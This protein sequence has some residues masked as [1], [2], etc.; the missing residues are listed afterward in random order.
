MR[1]GN[2]SVDLNLIR[3]LCALLEE[4]HVSHAADRC[5]V[6]QP[7]MSRMLDRLRETFQ[8]ELLVRSG[9]RYERT[10]RAEQLLAEMRDVLDRVDAAISGDRFEPKR[11]DATFRVATT[12]YFSAV[13]IPQLLAELEARAPLATLELHMSDDRT[14]EHVIAG[15]IDV[16][17]VSV[18]VPPSILR[19]EKLF[20]D[21]YVCL[22]A[23]DHPSVRGRRLGLKQYLEQRHVVIDVEHGV[24]PPVERPLAMLGARRRVGYRT[25]FLSSAV[26]AAAASSLVLTVPRRLADMCVTGVAV[27]VV[28]APQELDRFSYSLVWHNRLESSTAHTW[29]RDLIRQASHSRST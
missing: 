25:P 21:Q 18:G 13:M 26:Y 6:T 23:I 16:G 2:G 24:Q 10:P 20:D 3:A 17:I 7:A 11:C 15:R 9:R 29:F 4:R 8:D 27:R 14:F 12:D 22:V 28:A 19:S 1:L 5:N